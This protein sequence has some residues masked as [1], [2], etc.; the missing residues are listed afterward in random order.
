MGGG[1]VGEKVKVRVG[2]EP[3]FDSAPVSLMV[4]GAVS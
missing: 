3:V 4:W 1:A 2:V